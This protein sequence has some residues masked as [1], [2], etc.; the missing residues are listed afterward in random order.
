MLMTLLLAAAAVTGSNH[1]M[2]QVCGTQIGAPGKEMLVRNDGTPIFDLQATLKG[3]PDT[4]ALDE[5]AAISGNRPVAGDSY[6]IEARVSD[7]IRWPVSVYTPAS[8]G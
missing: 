4:T 5:I 6:C 1:S 3:E 8:F 2:V 7:G